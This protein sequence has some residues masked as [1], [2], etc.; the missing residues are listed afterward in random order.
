MAVVSWQRVVTP[1]D[2]GGVKLVKWVGLTAS[3]TGQPF[4]VAAYPDKTVQFLGTFGGNVLIE[5]SMDTDPSTAVYATLNDPQGNAL[6]VISA[7]KVENVLE[8][9]YLLRPSAGA[10]VSSVDVWLLLSNV[11]G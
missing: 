2:G 4:N 1:H 11:R 6:S 7:A 3:D 9:V 10:G 8:H 5:G